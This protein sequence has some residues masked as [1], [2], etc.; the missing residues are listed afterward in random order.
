MKNIVFNDLPLKDKCVIVDDY[1][2]ELCS[3]EHYDHRIYLYAIND[4]FIESYHNIETKEIER[5]TI[6]E[7]KDMGKFLPWITLSALLK[8]VYA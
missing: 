5:I 3:I 4:L 1:A 8:K 2:D 6:A 7:Y